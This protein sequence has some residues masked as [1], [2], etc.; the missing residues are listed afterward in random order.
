MDSRWRSLAGCYS[1]P[2]S[3]KIHEAKDKKGA[4]SSL[5]P[6]PQWVLGIQEGSISACGMDRA[7]PLCSRKAGGGLELSVSGL[8]CRRVHYI[9]LWPGISCHMGGSF[10]KWLEGSRLFSGHIKQTS[11]KRQGSGS[12]VSSWSKA[13]WELWNF[14]IRI[15]SRAE[16]SV[17][18]NV[19][20]GPVGDTTKGFSQKTCARCE[21]ERKVCVYLCQILGAAWPTGWLYPNKGTQN[22]EWSG[23]SGVC[24]GKFLRAC[25]FLADPTVYKENELVVRE[26][27]DL[28]ETR[29]FERK[30]RR[31]INLVLSGWLFKGWTCVSVTLA[32]DC[33]SHWTSEMGF[34][35]SRIHWGVVIWINDETHFSSTFQAIVTVQGK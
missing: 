26:T 10:W 12:A 7:I 35:T 30:I 29:G 22:L 4:L 33:V 31:I 15:S 24:L 19:E 11:Q 17:C 28:F 23:C 20:I 18:V 8:C 9:R 2:T 27:S 3:L 32:V 1:F 21:F 14:G 6:E 16:V 25:E 5:S 34:S 13:G